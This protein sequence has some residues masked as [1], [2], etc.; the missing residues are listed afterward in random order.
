MGSSARCFATNRRTSVAFSLAALVLSATCAMPAQEPAPVVPQAQPQVPVGTLEPGLPNAPSTA[1]SISGTVADTD[2]AAIPA[3]KV[4]LE[5]TD[6]KVTRSTTSDAIGAFSFTGIP[7]GKYI[8]RISAPGFASWKITDVIVLHEAEAFLIPQ[9][10]LGVEAINTTVN[11]ITQEDL[12]EQQITAEEHQRILGILPNFFVT[13]VPNAAPLTSRQKFKLAFVVSTDPLTFMTTGI[14]AGIEQAQGDFSGYGSG[15]PGYAKRYGATY[16][17]RLSATFLGA[18][19][20]PTIF[21]QDPRYFYRGHGRVITRA[22]YAIS[23]TVICKGDN[24]HFQPNYSNVLGNLGAAF[25]SGTYYPRDQQHTVQVTVS[26]TLLGV[27]YGAFG[28]L[29]QE[30]LL[31]HVTHGAPPLPAKTASP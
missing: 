22:L 11:A 28:T 16:G 25:I 12:A 9:V 13:Y 15:F 5:D 6:S 7:Q 20:F 8:V 18:A 2:Q 1:A 4:S 23:T 30:F 27:A 3:A 29:F 31:R 21:H 10:Q 17:N 19:F 24:G 14:T 26:D